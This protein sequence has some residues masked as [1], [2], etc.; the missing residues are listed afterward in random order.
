[1]NW[2]SVHFTSRVTTKQRGGDYELP[3]LPH[4]LV[5]PSVQRVESGA[6]IH[7]VAEN[8]TLRIFV[9]LIPHLPTGSRR[10][11]NTRRRANSWLLAANFS[12][13]F[14]LLRGSLPFFVMYG[15]QLAWTNL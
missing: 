2:F 10:T 1:M 8:A 15:W 7:I 12:V 3:H 11:L 6:A 14:V 13:Y 4:G 9:K 5:D